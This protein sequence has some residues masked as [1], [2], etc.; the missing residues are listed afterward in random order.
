MPTTRTRTV[1]LVAGAFAVGALGL[2]GVRALLADDPI[3]RIEAVGVGRVGAGDTAAAPAG[4]AGESRRVIALESLDGTLT[5]AGDDLDDLA[6]DN[7]ELDFGPEVWLFLAEPGQDYDGDG[8]AEALVDELGGMTGRDVELLVR[9]DDDRDDADVYVINGLDYRDTAGGPA[10]WDQP[11]PGDTPTAT[12]DQLIAAA[13][14][15]VGEGARV[16]DL[17]REERGAW[18]AE[19]VDTDGLE[20][21]VFLDAAGEVLDVRLDD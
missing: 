13:T 18:E 6:V 7:V 19:V 20:H 12:T 17:D 4:T 21:R 3:E 8:D 9:F 1:A 15:A 2:F 16:T 5:L 11:D 14:G 10:P